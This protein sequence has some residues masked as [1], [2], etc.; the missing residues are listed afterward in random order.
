MAPRGGGAKSG[1]A[2]PKLRILWS[3]T[4]F[5]GPKR[6]PNPLKT[7]KRR[8]TV[9]TL[10][11][12]LDCPV[13]KSP[14]LPSN[15][16]ICPRNGPKMAKNG[17]NVRYLCPTRPKT[18][19]ILGYV[20]QKQ[21]PRA[22]SPPATPHFLWFPSLRITQRDPYT[23]VPVVTSCSWRAAQPAHGRGQRWVHQGLR[24]EK[25]IFFKGVPSPLGMLKQ[26]FLGHFEPVVAR[27]GP[28]K[29]PKCI[30]NGPF[31]DQK[32]VKN[33]SKTCFSKSAPAPLGVHKRIKLARFELVLTKFSPFRHMYA[34]SCTLHTYLGAVWWSHVE[35][36]RG[37]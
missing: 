1:G 9:P 34:P 18:G 10:H 21:V 11:V 8:Q 35:L 14:F 23:P 3:K 5:F 36:G 26:V 19:R 33:G 13:T 22:P 25:K 32:W 2:L 30:E 28:W 37:V 16:T 24:G 29:I 27:Y 7:G 20:A 4:A 6:P 31:Q 12:R 17:L 15:S